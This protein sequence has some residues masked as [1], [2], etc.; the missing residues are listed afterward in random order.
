MSENNTKAESASEPQSSPTESVS[1]E[2]NTTSDDGELEKNENGVVILKASP[3]DTPPS[4]VKFGNEETAQK[5]DDAD[6][7]TSQTIF[8]QNSSYKPSYMKSD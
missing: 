2:Q 4:Y 6:K 5:Y 8:P 7:T 3:Y 1:E